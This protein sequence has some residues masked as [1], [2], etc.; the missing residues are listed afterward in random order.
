MK[1][2]GADISPDAPRRL[3]DGYRCMDELCCHFLLSAEEV[4]QLATLAGGG[5][6]Q[7]RE[8]GAGQIVNVYK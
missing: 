5:D 4:D 8:G 6:G 7:Q 1:R 2:R 3:D